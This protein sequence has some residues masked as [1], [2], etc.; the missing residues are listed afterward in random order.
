MTVSRPSPDNETK[1]RERRLETVIRNST[2]GF[3]VLD[4]ADCIVSANPAAGR[5]LETT[6]EALIGTP[7]MATCVPGRVAT[8]EYNGHLSLELSTAAMEWGGEQVRLIAISRAGQPEQTAVPTSS[9]SLNAGVNQLG[10]MALHGAAPAK[11]RQAAA[12]IACNELA[13][14]IG[15]V[16]EYH[17]ETGTALLVAG[18]GFPA[19]FIG[20]YTM[21]VDRSS[22]A[23]VALLT[24]EPVIVSD[25][26]EEDRFPGVQALHDQGVISGINV[27]V[28]GNNGSMVEPWGVIGVHATW[29][30]EFTA[31]DVEFLQGLANVLAQ[32]LQHARTLDLKR[33]SD[34]LLQAAGRTARLGGWEVD[35][36]ADHVVWSEGVSM[37][38]GLPP[39]RMTLTHAEA[40]RYVVPEYRANASQAMQQCFRD[41][42]P[43]DIE[44]KILTKDGQHRWVRTTGEPVYDDG[45]QIV[46]ARGA[47]QDITE[48]K[49]TE[50]EINFL[51]LYDPLTQLPNRRLLE[52]R[53]RQA[54]AA[55][56]RAG[57]LSALMLLDLDN[58]KTLNDTLGHYVGDRLLQK[59]AT[60]LRNALRDTD[61]VARFGGDEFILIVNDLGNNRH[62]AEAAA[63]R[64][65]ENL[66]ATLKR[67]YQLGSLERFST[68]S[69]GVTIFGAEQGER[70]ADLL[71]QAD[72]AMYAAKA[73]GRDRLCLFNPDMQ[74]AVSVRATMEA[75]MRHGLKH[76]EFCAYYQPQVDGD[77]RVIGA[78]T[79][80][81]WQHP[82]RGLVSPAE[83]IPLAEETRL[84]MP[85]GRFMLQTACD[86]LACWARNPDTAHLTLAVNVSAEQFHHSDFV[87]RV[88]AVID[89]AG[90]DP[91]RLVL[92]LTESSV[93]TGI[94]DTAEKMAALESHGVTFSLDDFGTGYSSLY[95]LKHLPLAELKIDQSF[96]RRIHED[97]GNEAI[98]RTIIA[99][100]TS[101]EL[102]TIAEG[103]ESEEEREL[104]AGLGCR[105]YQGFLFSKPQPIEQFE[106]YLT[107]SR[108][109]PNTTTKGPDTAG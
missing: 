26:R 73:R 42:T 10:A 65:G 82:Q 95:Y 37:I 52:D 6:H 15:T 14:D 38:H 4:N 19:E 86:Q 2:T 21:P 22:Q 74:A 36:N 107:Q 92:E 59:V 76:G 29:K 77:G 89:K 81:R 25:W 5:L 58:F 66:F 103:V 24:G 41:G 106:K 96:V 17:A 9:V 40:G 47:V 61:T 105:S 23:S 53:L 51:A 79:L 44:L 30:R 55:G 50:D 67:P 56:H 100:A 88:L 68:Q 7:L 104:L 62:E 90:A 39:E 98:A 34:M 32:A 18:S 101:L 84:I 43:I 97:A 45:G 70:L 71:K 57:Y 49:S 1:S 91:N 87:S 60:R 46:R 83:F 85:L 33:D 13:V 16:L 94:D 99:L 8:F 64:I 78:E 12:V 3:V 28:P 102:R 27:V 69:I 31:H 108:N 109:M 93:V 72:M 54:L 11:L 63:E 80:A 75:E 35:A 20:H 48:R